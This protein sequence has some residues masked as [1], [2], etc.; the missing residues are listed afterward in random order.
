MSVGEPIRVIGC[1]CS[2]C[3]YVN[4]RE[5]IRPEKLDPVLAHAA[6]KTAGLHLALAHSKLIQARELLQRAGVAGRLCVEL[7]NVEM[8]IDDTAIREVTRLESEATV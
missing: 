4:Q 6:V 2:A 3:A 1:G 7:E 8:F 5:R